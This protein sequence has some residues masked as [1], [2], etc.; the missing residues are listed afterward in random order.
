MPTKSEKGKQ[1]TLLITKPSKGASPQHVACILD[2][3]SVDYARRSGD[4]ER[5]LFIYFLFCAPP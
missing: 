4:D 3:N 1:Q 2:V 5:S